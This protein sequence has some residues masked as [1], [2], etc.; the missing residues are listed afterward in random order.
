[1]GCIISDELKHKYKFHWEVERIRYLGINITN[2]LDNLFSKNFEELIS[3]IKQD[4]NRWSII[5]LSLWERVKI[6]KMNI[7]PRF[8]F[9]FKALPIYIVSNIFKQWDSLITQFI[10]NGRKPRI[11]MK[12]LKSPKEKGGLDLPNLQDYY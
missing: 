9:L 3:Q 11:K 2:N 7:L 8:L 10:W 1:M 5:P 12:Y 6:I 4:L